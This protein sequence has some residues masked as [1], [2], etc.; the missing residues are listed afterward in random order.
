[1]RCPQC[2]YVIFSSS[3]PCYLKSTSP[4]LL[5]P[6]LHQHYQHFRTGLYQSFGLVANEKYPHSLQ[7]IK[8]H[9]S[10][11]NC[12]RIPF[13]LRDN[14]TR[15][16]IFPPAHHS[17]TTGFKRSIFPILAHPSLEIASTI[18]SYLPAVLLGLSRRFHCNSLS[19]PSSIHQCHLLMRRRNI[20]YFMTHYIGQ[21]PIRLPILGRPPAY[22]RNNHID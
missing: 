22:S 6:A 17:I 15:I 18:G 8:V 7:M 5:S 12:F 1:M 16:E 21:H 19:A 4:V 10:V 11:S 14:S 2:L 3:T 9:R 13:F 20:I